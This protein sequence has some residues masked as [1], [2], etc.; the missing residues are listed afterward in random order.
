AKA[1]EAAAVR[2]A[3]GARKER[4]SSQAQINEYQKQ[5]K[6]IEARKALARR[7]TENSKAEIAKFNQLRD[8]HLSKKQGAE[9][10][11]AFLN[12]ES[13]KFEGY[14]QEAKLKALKAQQEAFDSQQRLRQAQIQTAKARLSA[15]SKAQS[16]RARTEAYQTQIQ[17]QKRAISSEAP[18]VSYK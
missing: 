8:Q 3:N 7:K 15:Q 17:A 9:K 16:Y 4:A 14:V 11:L 5:I 2:D 6:A 13:A 18:A 12:Q 1:L 10:E